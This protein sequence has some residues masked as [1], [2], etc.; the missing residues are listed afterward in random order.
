M[1][2]LMGHNWEQKEIVMSVEFLIYLTG[3]E[4]MA[5]YKFGS[6]VRHS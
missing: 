3:F 4:I 2:T 6:R 1:A 5:V